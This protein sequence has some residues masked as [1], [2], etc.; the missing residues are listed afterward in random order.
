MAEYYAVERHMYYHRRNGN[1]TPPTTLPRDDYVPSRD[2]RA[3]DFYDARGADY[4]MLRRLADGLGTAVTKGDAAADGNVSDSSTTACVGGSP[5]STVPAL[6]ASPS[7]PRSRSPVEGFA[8]LAGPAAKPAAR[9]TEQH[10]H[11]GNLGWDML[12]RLSPED[13]KAAEEA[14]YF[15]AAA[16][17]HGG[18]MASAR[19]QRC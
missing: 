7:P 3:G 19:P 2:R 16:G 15:P 4:G 1:R 14:L 10:R 18:M 13:R 12:Q 9:P 8:F 17:Q 11:V 6:G 5:S